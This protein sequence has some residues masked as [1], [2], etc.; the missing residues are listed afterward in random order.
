[1]T[2]RM[3]ATAA[4]TQYDNYIGVVCVLSPPLPTQRTYSAT[5]GVAIDVPGDVAGDAAVLASQ[6]FVALG[7]SGTTAAR[8]T[9]NLRPGI[10]HID[11]TLGFAVFYDGTNWRNPISGAS[12]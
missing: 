11:T 7:S 8:P 9:T 5:V 2:I 10:W 3:F 12:V 6:G 1:M 4:A